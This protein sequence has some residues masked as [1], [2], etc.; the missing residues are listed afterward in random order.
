[1]NNSIEIFNLNDYYYYIHYRSILVLFL[2]RNLVQKSVLNKILTFLTS[3]YCHKKLQP[4]INLTADFV[5]VLL[6][7]K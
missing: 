7:S 5:F 6:K 2:F 3:N 4:L 1:M